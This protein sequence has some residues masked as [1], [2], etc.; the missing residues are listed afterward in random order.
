VFTRLGLKW[1]QQKKLLAPD[2]EAGQYK[3]NQVYPQLE[4]AWLHQTN[5]TL[6]LKSKKASQV[7]SFK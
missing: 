1:V 3:L 2:A 7:F 5:Q 6:N 4:S